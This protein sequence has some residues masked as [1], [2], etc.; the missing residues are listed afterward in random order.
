MNQYD[1]K[2]LTLQIF[3]EALSQDSP[4]SNIDLWRGK[5]KEKGGKKNEN[6]K[7]KLRIKE[8]PN[9][10]DK[11]NERGNIIE[12]N[13]NKNLK[14]FFYKMYENLIFRRAKRLN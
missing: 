1:E 3:L 12:K 2:K 8:T 6:K 7:R 11:H 4:G 5:I 13:K 10:F 14:P 9:F